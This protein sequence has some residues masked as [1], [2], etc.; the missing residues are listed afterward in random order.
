MTIIA[1]AV[2]KCPQ[3]KT[4]PFQGAAYLC[5]N[6]SELGIKKRDTIDLKV[7]VRSRAEL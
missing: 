1:K 3:Q 5:A 2:A 6:R 4:A 7:K